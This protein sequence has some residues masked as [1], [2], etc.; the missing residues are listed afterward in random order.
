M[1][2]DLA[3]LSALPQ[4][5]PQI[6]VELGELKT[7]NEDLRAKVEE[8]Y[9]RTLAQKEDTRQAKDKLALALQEVQDLK[10]GRSLPFKKVEIGLIFSKDRNRRF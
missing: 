2:A 5:E 1:R 3:R 4:I 6:L 8:E 10:V 9:N 7:S